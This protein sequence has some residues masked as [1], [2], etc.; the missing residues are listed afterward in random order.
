M[1]MIL[2]LQIHRMVGKPWKNTNEVQY[3][4]SF[5]V[6]SSVLGVS[7]NPCLNMVDIDGYCSA[8]CFVSLM[9]AT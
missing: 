4:V 3:H 6:Y 9:D 7:E 5:E 2:R 1:P 8:V